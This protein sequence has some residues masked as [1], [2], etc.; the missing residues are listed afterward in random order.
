MLFAKTGQ[1]KP[2]SPDYDQIINVT[3]EENNVAFVEKALR[4]AELTPE[5]R[6]FCE[7][8]AYGLNATQAFLRSRNTKQK[9]TVARVSACRLMKTPRIA[10]RIEQIRSEQI[11]GPREKKLLDHDWVRLEVLSG[12]YRIATSSSNDKLRLEAWVK[13]GQSKGVELFASG[14]GGG[15]ATVNIQSNQIQQQ[16]E[17][18]SADDLREKLVAEMSQYVQALPSPE[19]SEENVI[20]LTPLAVGEE[21]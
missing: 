9:P 18:K 21:E 8:V 6:Q 15:S 4:E 14:G 1:V 20:D 19:E 5:D 11:D 16:Y 17:A 12:L 3:P 2:P 10:Q 7:L 13:L